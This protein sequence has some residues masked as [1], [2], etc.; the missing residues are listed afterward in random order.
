MYSWNKNER[1]AEEADTLPNKE[2]F[3]EAMTS[4]IEDR[5][6]NDNVQV[7]DEDSIREMVT[8]V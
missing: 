6:N 2:E 4:Y 7:W 3:E 8:M 1:G 5:Q